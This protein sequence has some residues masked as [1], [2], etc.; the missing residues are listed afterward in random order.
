MTSGPPPVVK[1]GKG[2][3]RAAREG[4]LSVL[5]GGIGERTAMAPPRSSPGQPF[6]RETE[7]LEIKRLKEAQVKVDEQ[8]KELTQELK[9]K[10]ALLASL[11][12]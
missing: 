8:T 4:R 3:G 7:Q 9:K 12:T 11:R 6:S 5:N 2:K 1:G 10:E